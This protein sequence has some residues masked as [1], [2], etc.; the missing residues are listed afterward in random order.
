[1][2]KE[3][4]LRN[5]NWLWLKDLMNWN[6]IIFLLKTFWQISIKI[7]FALSLCWSHLMLAL[8]LHLTNNIHKR[9]I[10]WM[11]LS[12]NSMLLFLSNINLQNVRNKTVPVWKCKKVRI[13]E[14]HVI[15]SMKKVPQT[16][17]ND[18]NRKKCV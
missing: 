5:L 18:G 16:H 6:L 14:K 7:S 1:M 13:C 2:L 17:N 12:F 3:H 9:F 11:C 4:F 10:I 15:L 8:L